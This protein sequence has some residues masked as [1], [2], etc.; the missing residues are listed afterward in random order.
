[1]E[2][3]WEN[4][5][6]IAENKYLLSTVLSKN[7]KLYLRDKVTLE[8]DPIDATDTLP[9]IAKEVSIRAVRSVEG[10]DLCGLDIIVNPEQN[11]VTVIELNTRPMLGLHIFPFKGVP[12]DVITPIIDHYF[13]ETKNKERTNLYF[14]LNAIISP[15]RERVSEKVVL[16]PLLII[17]PYRLK[18]ATIQNSS[19]NQEEL[20]QLRT[21]ARELQING[22]I[23]EIN[24]DKWEVI[25]GGQNETLLDDFINSFRDILS[26][27]SNINIEALDE[28]H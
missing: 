27:S 17:K 19:I 5:K 8:G 25:F 12:R 24:N 15:I 1:M 9:E 11:R 22:L 20:R 21:K 4:K 10:L 16:N 6:K 23:S 14:D 28:N 7:E 3:N 13:P 18:R 26:N 2:I